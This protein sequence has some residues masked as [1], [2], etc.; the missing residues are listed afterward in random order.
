MTRR[1]TSISL[2]DMSH[3]DSKGLEEFDKVH[4][5]YFGQGLGLGFFL[6]GDLTWGREVNWWPCGCGTVTQHTVVSSLDLWFV[7]FILILFLC[8]S[9]EISFALT[10]HCEASKWIIWF[11]KQHC[12]WL[13]TSQNNNVPFER[14]ELIMKQACEQHTSHLLSQV[15]ER[16]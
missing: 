13:F 14:T 11:R 7:T 8:R 2:D 9:W 5:I 1:M 16:K 6:S 12:L 15:G 3:I 4:H 10:L